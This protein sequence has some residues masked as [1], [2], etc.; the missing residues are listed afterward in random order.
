LPT[1]YY[2]VPTLEAARP[3]RTSASPPHDTA[4]PTDAD[5]NGS[6]RLS[7]AEKGK[8]RATPPLADDP[9]RSN[10][11]NTNG[12]VDPETSG[13]GKRTKKKR[14]L[15]AGEEIDP[16]TLDEHGQLRANARAKKSKV[17]SDDSQ[18]YAASASMAKAGPSHAAPQPLAE[19]DA[20]AAPS[21]SGAD[22]GYFARLERNAMR[23][24]LR[25][26]Q[27][28][29]PV[30]AKT[31]RAL[32]VGV[33]YLRRPRATRGASVDIGLGGIARGVILE[34]DVDDAGAYWGTKRMT[35]SIVVAM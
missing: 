30:W 23:P 10:S 22:E 34:G 4:Q 27:H 3:L 18:A 20:S 35:G 29:C 14:R 32:Q 11:H 8:G 15:S 17:S 24:P 1:R 13:R 26:M 5:T 12:Y 31:R 19:W 7:A 6:P 25:D 21:R 16:E 33:D 9:L 28:A 2:S